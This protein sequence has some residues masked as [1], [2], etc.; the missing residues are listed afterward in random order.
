VQGAVANK[1]SRT[2]QSVLTSHRLSPLQSQDDKIG[3]SMEDAGKSGMSLGMIVDRSR[4]TVR[5]CGHFTDRLLT[6]CG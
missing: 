2:L 6:T 1:Q 3:A 5:S 4:M